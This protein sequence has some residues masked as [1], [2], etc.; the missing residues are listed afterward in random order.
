LSLA[1]LLWD[2]GEQPRQRTAGKGGDGETLAGVAAYARAIG[3][4]GETRRPAEE[5][6]A[7]ATRGDR[8]RRA[9]RRR[10]ARPAADDSV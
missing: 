6:R 1:L 7:L 4:D 5:A 3:R 10:R 8:R 2:A 9:G